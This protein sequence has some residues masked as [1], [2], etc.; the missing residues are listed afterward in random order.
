MA[1]GQ[2]LRDRMQESRLVLAIVPSLAAIVSYWCVYMFRYPLFLLQD[3]DFSETKLGGIGTKTWISIASTIGM[4]LAKAPA[5]KVISSLKPQHRFFMTVAT[6]VLGGIGYTVLLP[7]DIAWLA[8]LGVAL[9][10]FPTSWI[11]GIVLTNFEGRQLT[12]V[13]VAALNCVLVFGSSSARAIGKWLLSTVVPSA[14]LRMPLIAFG[15]SL[16]L[17]LVST[18]IVSL[19]P[20]QTQQDIKA[21]AKRRPMTSTE[22]LTFIRKYWPGLLFVSVS[23]MIV[24]S[25]RAFRDFFANELYTALLGRPPTPTDFL[26]ADWPG[27]ICACF[28][29]LLL[30]RAK[31][32]IGAVQACM[33]LIILGGLCLT[34]GALA[35]HG[36]LVSPSVASATIGC[37]VFLCVSSFTGSLYDR[38]MAV[39]QTDGTSVFLVY[40]SDGM[41]YFGTCVLLAIRTFGD[42]DLDYRS[43][44]LGSAI[45]VG[46]AC[47]VLAALSLV[48]FSRKSKG[49]LPNTTNIGCDDA[50]ACSTQAHHEPLLDE[51]QHAEP[52]PEQGFDYLDQGIHEDGVHETL[53]RSH[54]R[55]RQQ[56]QQVQSHSPPHRPTSNT[57]SPVDVVATLFKKLTGGTTHRQ[58]SKLPTDKEDQQQPAPSGPNLLRETQF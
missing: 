21:K 54:Q 46:I 29:L 6:V 18:Y 5:I 11:F 28:A 23:Y 33:V 40:I 30:S 8:V 14:P 9:G 35:F 12:D 17:F 43:F 41:A 3:E 27:G 38:L 10:A 56:R 42:V 15:S 36:N 32:N 19:I 31:T 37:G 4:A 13:Y 16:P 1:I 58:Y 20:P 24:M 52:E 45:L 53:H 55:Q 44:F 50:N 25:L 39:T 7:L 51:A 47:T 57:P 49:M 2:S 26:I 48:Y 22:Q 34:G